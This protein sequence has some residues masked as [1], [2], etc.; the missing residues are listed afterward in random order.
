MFKPVTPKVDVNEV[1]REQMAFWKDSDIMRRSMDE[2]K[3]GPRYVFY[4]GPPTANG[5]PGSHHVLARAFKDMFPRYKTMRGYYS[6]RRGGWDTHGLPVEIEVEKELGIKHKHE[7]DAYGIAAFNEKCRESVLRYIDE[8]NE[9]TERIAF[10]VDLDQ[11]YVTFTND[12]IQSVW[13]ILRQFWDKELL[14]QGYKVV[15][16]C[17]RCG[18][19][20][21]SH[22]V[23]LGY[24][25][26]TDDPSVFV[27]FKL[28][29]KDNQFLLAWTTTPWTLPGNMLLAVGK[30]VDYVTV[31]G[32]NRDGQTERLTLGKAIIDKAL[33]EDHNYKVVAEMKGAELVGLKYEPLFTFLPSEED[34]AYV[35]AGEFVSTE[36]GTGI[37]HI[38]PAFGADDLEMGKR[39]GLT[40]LVTVNPQGEFVAEVTP[41]AGMWV[42]D[43]DPEIEKELDGRGLLY[44]SG[45]YLHTYPFC[46]RCDTALLYYARPTWFIA[47]STLKDRLVDLNNTI[48]WVPDHIRTGRFGDW[49]NNNVDW[50]LGRERYWGTPLPVWVCD[51]CGHQHCVGG[52]D[53]LT[54]LTGQ[55]QTEL[56]MHRPYVD[57]V[58]WGCLECGE[59]SMRRVPELIDV[60]FD[61]GAMPLAQWGYPYHNKEAFEDQFPATYICE[62]IDQTRG[63]FYSLHAIATLLF[64][65]VSFENVIC[66][67]HILDE[68]A[69]KM[70]KSKGNVV[71]PWDVINH[72][73]ADAFRW[74]CYTAGPPGDSRRFSE[75]LV[76][77][78]IRSFW[79]T[80]WNTYSFFVNLANAEGFDPRE[81][82]VPVDKRDPL[83]RWILAELNALVHDVTAA[84][85][86]YDV[87]NATRPIEKFVDDMSK[88]Y[89]RRSRRRFWRG[90]SDSDRAAY[91]TLYECLVTVSKL[92]AP[93]MPFLSEALY[94]NLVGTL[95]DGQPESVHLA[96]WPE[97]DEALVDQ[98]L[99]DEMTLVRRLVSMGHAARNTAQIKVRQPMADAAFSV[100]NAEEAQVV[101]DYAELFQDELNVKAVT[102]LDEPGDVVTYSLNP[103]PDALGP[104]FGKDFPKV[105]NSLREGDGKLTAERA[106]LLM[107]GK[108]VTV[109]LNGE[110]VEVT[111]NEVEVRQEPAQ[112]YAIGADGA[113]MA[114]LK[115]DLSE[116]LLQEGLAREVVRR[117]QTL[118]K[119]ADLNVDDRI[120]VTYHTDGRL[121]Q[122]IDAHRAFIMAETLAEA[123]EDGNSGQAYQIEGQTFTVA[124]ERV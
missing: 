97:F 58:T 110:D 40:P 114:A 51:H 108:P 17:P 43:A 102:V 23:N 19:P 96:L 62:A 37:V 31:E 81:V 93:S 16:Y 9:L 80:L 121:A 118:R 22:E 85:E 77:E 99:M 63:W 122:A 56:D 2:R 14:Y 70:S 86:A 117:I 12:Y 73:G 116:E 109:T 28:R 78:V 72:S 35:V 71:D 45:R 61:S 39:E 88:W 107:A 33:G 104:R 10:W 67:G 44:K 106:Q 89:V 98:Q 36:E 5:K 52:V 92:L 3:D 69:S 13:W 76:N 87:P 68:N 25:D 79:L 55:D 21:S 66:L 47:T 75:G 94:R 64:D 7:I 119:E 20:L 8:W 57:E 120:Q 105:Q 27:R 29:D 65:S 59:G 46:W 1:E 95:D 18:T 113:Y 30:D 48:N 34:Y 115:T 90:E 4:E 42:K 24:K 15:P 49:L 103:L 100:G 111:P 50:A 83:D 54:D 60:W 84:Y 91:L 123:M 41:W 82:N 112:G 6:L 124:I 11:A 32:Q 38:A 74:Y 26:D 53:E 101:R